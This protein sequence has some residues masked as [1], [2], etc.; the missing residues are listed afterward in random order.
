M[1]DALSR[2][3]LHVPSLMIQKRRFEKFRDMNLSITLSH[4]KMQLN[5][6]H[7]NSNLQNQIHEAQV[8]DEFIQK[9]KKV[10]RKQEWKKLWHK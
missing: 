10:D 6:S 9:K 8:S 2:K 4:D 5:S 3:S 7:I 1:V